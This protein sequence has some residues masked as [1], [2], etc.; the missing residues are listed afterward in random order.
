MRRLQDVLP[1]HRLCVF[2]DQ[3]GQECV[4]KGEWGPG[5]KN[6]NLL[7]HNEHFFYIM[8][9]CT[10][11]IYEYECEKCC[12]FFHN[13]LDHR[14]AGSCWR[15][16]GPVAHDDPTV[17]LLRCQR[18]H[19]QFS[20]EECME[21]HKSA[22]LPHSFLTKCEAF[23]FCPTCEKSYSTLRGRKHVCGFVYCRNCKEN[24]AENHL[25]YMTAWSEKQPKKGRHYLTVFYDIETTQNTP[26]LGKE[27]T[28][29]HKPNLI[30]S[31]TI[32]KDCANVAQN[33]YFC[34]V[35]NTRQHIFHT[36]KKN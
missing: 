16:L 5:R 20:G 23:K 8:Y 19:H 33:D 11:F 35:C 13:K 30:V 3:K 24:V 7:L 10:V 1:D 22:K 29:E 14:C 18:C 17:P 27:N 15:C 12:S 21:H 6:I 36:P 25:C 34:R 4:F 2:T 28:F 9:P 32:C 31:Q 26:V